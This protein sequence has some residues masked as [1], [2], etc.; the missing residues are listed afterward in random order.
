MSVAYN[1]TSSLICLISRVIDYF[2]TVECRRCKVQGGPC[3]LSH[4]VCPMRVDGLYPSS[5]KK[6]D[7][8]IEAHYLWQG[9]PL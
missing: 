4:E 1:S 2:V 6:C 8:H 3:A 7:N 9:E 5:V